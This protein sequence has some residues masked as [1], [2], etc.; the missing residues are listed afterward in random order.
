MGVSNEV[1]PYPSTFLPF[2]HQSKAK[3]DHSPSMSSFTAWESIPS[4]VAST[5][6]DGPGVWVGGC[7]R[8][9]LWIKG[10]MSSLGAS[11]GFTLMWTQRNEVQRV[12]WLVGAE[13]Q[14]FIQRK[15]KSQTH[16]HPI[17]QTTPSLCSIWFSSYVSNCAFFGFPSPPPTLNCAFEESVL[18][19]WLPQ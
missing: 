14:P 3:G 2:L 9:P 7:L 4:V 12:V 10:M 8:E 13:P 11:E 16:P 5:F 15:H 1:P 19:P 6:V 18:S 17:P